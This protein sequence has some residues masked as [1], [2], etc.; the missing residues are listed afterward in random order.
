MSGLTTPEARVRTRVNGKI[1]AGL[2][3]VESENG[4]SVM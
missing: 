3:T 4:L 1:R 2:G